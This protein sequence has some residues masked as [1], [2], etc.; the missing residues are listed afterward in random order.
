MRLVECELSRV[1]IPFKQSFS[2]AAATRAVSD[3][4]VVAIRTDSGRVG[5]GEIQAR[6]YVTGETND[7]IW[8]TDGPDIAAA[9]IGARI[10]SLADIEDCLGGPDAYARRPACVG[11]FDIAL[12]NCLELEAGLDWSAVFGAERRS[13]IQKCLTI[14]Q[15]MSDD[16]LRRQGRFARLKAC[17]VVKL[18]VSSPADAERVRTLRDAVGSDIAIRLDA[19]GMLEPAEV[20][21][22][23]ARCGGLG[24][25]SFEEP[26][27]RASAGLGEALKRLYEQYG[28]PF[29]ADE[30]ACTLADI[31]RFMDRSA[32]QVINVRVGKCGGVNGTARFLRHALDTG[33]DVVSGTMVG[34]TAVMLR[35]S[36]TMLGHCEALDYVEGLDQASVLTEAEVIERVAGDRDR[37][38][39]WRESARERYQT[40]HQVFS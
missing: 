36:E 16:A 32:Y 21:E 26:V 6:P 31:D 14:G 33:F 4:I 9:L 27:D 35:V 22:L 20:G 19:N 15:G 10:D 30:S 11:G 37:S 40:G 18:K 38:F 23:L 12:A 28:V 13:P 8:S 24:I 3:A 2:H 39:R 25:V 29:V 34:E 17:S 1:S 7:A 5:F